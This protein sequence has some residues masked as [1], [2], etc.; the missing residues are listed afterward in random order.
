MTAFSQTDSLKY[1]K[2]VLIDNDT[3]TQFYTWQ[4]RELAKD[5]VLKDSYN[6]LYMITEEQLYNCI[7]LSGNKDSIIVYKNNQIDF[8]KVIGLTK[9][10][11]GFEKDNII[12]SQEN[13]IYEME[14]KAKNKKIRNW[15]I[16]IAGIIGVEELF[17]N[18]Y[19][20][21]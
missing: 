12:L 14:R 6:E 7:I 10:S 5:I 3:V 16:A 15:V 20:N 18:I 11:I 13:I 17:R 9:D 4:A 8:L 2:T 21:K 19:K 1:P